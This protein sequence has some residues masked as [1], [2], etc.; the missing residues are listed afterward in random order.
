MQ[1]TQMACTHTAVMAVPAELD[2]AFLTEQQVAAFGL[3][4]STSTE[5]APRSRA[6]LQ[7]DG[8]ARRSIP[9]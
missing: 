4:A 7:L 8:T 5:A 9:S 2:V 3:A 1:K 6:V